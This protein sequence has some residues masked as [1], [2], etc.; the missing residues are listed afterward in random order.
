MTELYTFIDA[1]HYNIVAVLG[2]TYLASLRY[3]LY[4]MSKRLQKLENVPS[5][6]DFLRCP[7]SK[8]K[9]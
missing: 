1:N 2:V 9:K 8:T 5:V 4:K 6:K 7:K 3:G